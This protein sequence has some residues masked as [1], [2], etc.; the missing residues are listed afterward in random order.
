ML[1]AVPATIVIADLS[2]KQFISAIFVSAIALTCSQVTVP[3]FF[4][5]GSADPEAIF[6]AS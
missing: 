6:A 2:V 1:L 3:T 5:F 4:L